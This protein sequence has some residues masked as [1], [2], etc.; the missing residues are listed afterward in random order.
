MELL[1]VFDDDKNMLDEYVER[2]NKKELL[3]GKN[4]MIILLFIQNSEGEFLIQKV[5]K[6][7]GNVYATTGGHVTFKDNGIITVIKECEEELGFRVF[8]EELTLISVE[9]VSCCFIESYYLKKDIDIKDLKLQ[10]SEVES[11]EWLSIDEINEL[12]DTANF[13]KGNVSAFQKVLDF[14]N[15]EMV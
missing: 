12:I 14:L 13:R 5:S 15:K 6:E 4:F 2:E 11:V 1:Q 3:S 8:E 7:K 9:K 10:S